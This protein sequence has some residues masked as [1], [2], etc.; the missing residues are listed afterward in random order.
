MDNIMRRI[1]NM[2]KLVLVLLALVMVFSLVGCAEQTTEMKQTLQ[3]D[4]LINE[5]N[6]QIGMP[7]ITNFY[8]KKMAKDI[9]ELRDDADLVTYVYSKAMSGKYVYIGQGIG[10]GLP[11]S[12]Q[13]TNP[14]KY[15][16]VITKEVVD[17][18]GKDWTYDYQMVAQAEPNGLFMPEGLAATW[19]MLITED[20]ERE[21]AYFEEDI[22]V[23]Q[24]KMPARLCED[25]SLPENY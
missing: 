12:V 20:G 7:N 21:V 16:G 18:G 24:N 3:T 14:L 11:Y 13:Y 15:A 10:F 22:I 5:M 17:D 19:M 9:Y 6:N 25:W 23:R 2:K 1:K 4:A 8:E